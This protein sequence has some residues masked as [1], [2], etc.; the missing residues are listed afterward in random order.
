MFYLNYKNKLIKRIVLNFSVSFFLFSTFAVPIRSSVAQENQKEESP[1]NN[2]PDKNKGEEDIEYEDFTKKYK[3]R[4]NASLAA[5]WGILPGGGQIFNQ[6]YLA[7]AT[8]TTLFLSFM[9]IAKNNAR[10]EEYIPMDERVVQFSLQDMFF[11][12]ILRTNNLLYLDYQL[13]T[14][15]RWD[16]DL[17]LWRLKKIAEL[18]P[19][20]QYGS[21]ARLNY[22]SANEE[23]ASQSML[24]TLFYS[25][26][27]GY[28]DAG[29]IDEASKEENFLDLA[30]APFR[31]K[32]L[33]D[34]YV[35][36]PLL[37]LA[38]IGG[39]SQSVGPYTLVTPGMKSSG[40][41]GFLYTAV[42]FNAGVGEEAFFRGFLNHMFVQGSGPM[43]AGLIT[44][45]L[46]GIA[47]YEGGSIL[48]V[49][50]QTLFGFYTAYLHYK[51]NYDIKPGIALHFWWDV[52]VFG[53]AL[54]RYKED[55]N[56]DKNQREVHFM[57]TIF[58]MRF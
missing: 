22:A 26:Y 25:V 21:Y 57:P 12:D 37:V 56:V 7:G 48:S 27:S 29:G 43:E 36:T 51:Y 45:T 47:H 5:A 6:N 38:A 10:K 14:E 20:L 2:S 18:N 50:P 53:F 58:Q 4:E 30:V 46:F 49:W 33:L 42:S 19:L 44:G 11:A 35:F 24:H 55:P 54:A 31:P 15:T 17:R 52:I 41:L 23:L 8:Q 28:R 34:P 39:S 3:K 40:Y 13:F 16:R 32:Y 9:G 1:D